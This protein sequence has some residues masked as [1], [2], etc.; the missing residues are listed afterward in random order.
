MPTVRFKPTI[1]ADER[2]QTYDLDLAATRISRMTVRVSFSTQKASNITVKTM[3]LPVRICSYLKSI[4]KYK[5][6][7]L[8]TYHPDGL[9]PVTARSK[10]YVCGSSPAEIVGSN[11]TGEHGCLSVVSV[12]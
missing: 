5:I 4:P 10:A 11:P 12:V 8:V 3:L 2:L 6:L 9:V 7:I 1:S